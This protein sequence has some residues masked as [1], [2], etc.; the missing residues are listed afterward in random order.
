MLH[1]FRDLV[2]TIAA[3]I[4]HPHNSCR[5]ES[6]MHPTLHYTFFISFKVVAFRV[7]PLLYVII[8]FLKDDIEKFLSEFWHSEIADGYDDLDEIS[9]VDINSLHV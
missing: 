1:I 5:R 9:L 7:A 8:T 3:P 4:K 2:V 6:T